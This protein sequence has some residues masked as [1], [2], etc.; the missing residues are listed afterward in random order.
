[1]KT[2]TKL[3]LAR[4]I[5]KFLLI[6]GFKTK[7][8]CKRNKISWNLD[9]SEGIDLSLFLFGSFQKKLIYSIFNLIK[10]QKDKHYNFNIIDVGS[11]IGDKSL[12]LSKLLLDYGIKNFKVFSIEPTDYAYNKQIK[13]IELNPNLKNRINNYKLFI[14]SNR[15]KPKATYSSWFLDKTKKN[16]LIHGGILKKINLK[17]ETISLDK[18]ILLNRISKKIIIKIDVDG[19]E[20]DILK[21]LSNSIKLYSPIIFMEYAPYAFEEYGYKKDQFYKLI[22]KYKYSIYDLNYEKLK[23]VNVNEGSSKDIILSKDKLI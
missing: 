2:N 13:N 5:L 17:T 18:F 19:Y 8:I 9:I 1:M 16:H 11:N 4:I 15:K 3:L 10:N 12:V 6:I 21:S 14:S 22:N 23:Y 20:I 7:F